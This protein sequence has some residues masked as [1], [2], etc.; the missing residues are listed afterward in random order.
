MKS[1]RIWPSQGRVY[2]AGILGLGLACGLLALAHRSGTYVRAGRGGKVSAARF[3]TGA[4]SVPARTQ[5]IHLP[6][7]SAQAQIRAT[8]AGLPLRFEPNQGQ[9]DPSVKFLSRGSGYNL[10]LTAD[11]A[12]LTLHLPSASR[13]P[14]PETRNS[15]FE[16]R[17][18]HST[19][20]NLKSQIPQP[21]VP[22]PQ[23]LWSFA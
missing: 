20:Q 18:T 17:Q 3:E 6:A 12:V 15:T 8:Y 23:L 21:P 7:S 22:S 16:T 9:T 14:E 5:A 1:G 11:E 2:A 4:A 13:N 19:I 10:F